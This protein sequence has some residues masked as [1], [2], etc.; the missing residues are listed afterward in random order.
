MKIGITERG[1]AALDLSWADK[2]D[3]VDGAIVITKNVTSKKFQEALLEHKNK[4]ILHATIT[5]LG[6][7][8][9]EP[10]VPKA[11]KSI[12]ALKEIISKGFPASKI[13]FRLDPIL[14]RAQSH[15]FR[16][17]AAKIIADLGISRVRFSFID[18]YP[19]VRRRFMAKGIEIPCNN[20]TLDKDE[21]RFVALDFLNIN[22]FT[23]LCFEICA[24][25]NNI[26][27]PIAGIFEHIGCISQKDLQLLGIYKNIT[28]LAN[29]R[30][31][32]KCL[33][34]KT[35]LLSNKAQCAHGCV[36][37]YWKG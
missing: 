4:L 21:Q 5:F 23:G 31:G 27:D 34:V 28:S 29:Q 11:G 26:V 24:E 14:S 6:G 1:D 18:I 22:H 35:E 32:C 33:S 9:Y 3:S 19:H 36:Y 20:F 8:E 7:T 12:E 30:E 2:L 10:N 15:A 16:L 37:C 17:G 25:D 13:V